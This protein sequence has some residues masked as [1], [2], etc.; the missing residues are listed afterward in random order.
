MSVI[1]V[2]CV[3]LVGAS[4]LAHSGRTDSS[5][6]HTDHSTGDYH[7]HH[8]YPAHYHTGGVCPYTS[9]SKSSGSSSS[10]SGYS[11][12][13]YTYITPTIKPTPLQT[14]KPTPTKTPELT[15]QITP[16]ATKTASISKAATNPDAGSS[17]LS[18]AEWIA[19]IF[20]G[21]PIGVCILLSAYGF[22]SA[23]V[24]I[25][26]ENRKKKQVE[27]AKI[28]EEKQRYTEL[29]AGQPTEA[30]AKIPKG[31]YLDHANLPCSK[32]NGEWGAKYTRYISRNGTKFHMPGCKYAY[33]PIH[34]VR[35]KRY[36]YEPCKLCKAYLPDL[37][38]YEDYLDIKNK[39]EKYG[40]K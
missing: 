8:G 17:K 4:S 40:I 25:S 37:K 11:K 35:A 30:L 33:T 2:I 26:I 39:K 20:L 29:Y 22:I 19:I 9:S 21:I 10:Y 38:W 7:Y 3:L 24:E 23:V 27:K 6:G 34:A 16:K 13:A 12:P 15:P 5:G 1:L 14:P 28:A 31:D 18:V 36:G 32:G